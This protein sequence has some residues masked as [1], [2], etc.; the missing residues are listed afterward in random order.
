LIDKENLRSAVLEAAHHLFV[1]KGYENVGMR[2]IAQAVGKQPTQV[3]RLKL[4]K[5]D[6]L[7]ELILQL[8]AKQIERIPK[9]LSKIKGDNLYD[10]VCTYIERLYELDI[11]YLPLRSVGAAQGWSWSA[12][13]EAKNLEQVR[14]LIAPIA[15]WISEAGLKDVQGRS[16][17][18]F[19]LYYV[20]FRGAVIRKSSASEC[21]ES[22]KPSLSYFCK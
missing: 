10:K 2:D 6:I 21:L 15:S 20:G 17:G 9:I 8:N 16:I 18:I 12:D 7:A 19:S 13:Y 5:S 4:S 3:Y 22:I 11:E 1:S 14:H